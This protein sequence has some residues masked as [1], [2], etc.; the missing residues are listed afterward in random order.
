MSKKVTSLRKP[1]ATP[2]APPAS[3]VAQGDLPRDFFQGRLPVPAGQMILTPTERRFLEANGWKDGDPIPAN[4]AGTRATSAE[5]VAD[6]EQARAP[7]PLDTPRL[8][9]PEFADVHSFPAAK[10]TEVAQALKDAKEQQE[11][12][13][14]L[15]AAQ[16]VGPAGPGIKEAIAVA[17]SPGQIRASQ[18]PGAVTM[19]NDL[20][21]PA[22]NNA[23]PAQETP[24]PSVDEAGAAPTPKHCTHCGWDQALVDDLPISA[25]DLENY[26]VST[27]GLQRFRK[28]VSL[29]DGKMM[30][31]FRALT[32]READ[33]A[34]R[35]IA[36]DGQRDL[37][38]KQVLPSDSYW[39]NLMTYLMVMGIES[40]WTQTVG[41]IEF[42]E[43]DDMEVDEESCPAPNTKLYAMLP[44]VL[45]TALPTDTLRRVVGTAHH[46]FNLL[47]EKLEAR[48][49][50]ENFSKAI[51]ER[52]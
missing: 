24:Q 35:Q 16:P 51:G 5:A 33:L 1:T 47:V 30:V 49:D 21:P 8:Q 25:D 29:Y 45:E 28:Q 42:A 41:L 6:N 34:Y 11:M 37:S 44:M 50:G 2:L 27:L 39:R 17:M 9:V 48:A 46:K 36:I 12:F 32:T 43:L 13:N 14:R 7:V 18:L 3:S 22:S 19:E 31:T 20:Q 15:A 26:L 40:I 23:P 38:G 4:L 10:Q 52:V